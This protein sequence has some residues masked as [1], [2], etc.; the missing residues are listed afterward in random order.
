MKR[1]QNCVLSS[2][3]YANIAFFFCIE[4]N[5]IILDVCFDGIKLPTWNNWV[6]ILILGVDTCYN[7]QKCPKQNPHRRILIQTN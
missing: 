3:G 5:R 4:S 2:V 1:R 7:A 6:E